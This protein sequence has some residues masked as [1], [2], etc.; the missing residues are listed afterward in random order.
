MFNDEELKLIHILLSNTQWRTQDAESVVIAKN[1]LFK[2]EDELKEKQCG[3]DSQ[4]N[5]SA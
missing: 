2:I 1:I 3:E 5:C 4:Q